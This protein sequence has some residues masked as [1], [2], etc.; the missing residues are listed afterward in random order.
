MVEDGFRIIYS[1]MDKELIKALAKARY[2]SKRNAGISNNRYDGSKCSIDNDIDATGAEYF[3]V[4]QY[5][6]PFNS[7]IGSKGDGGSD[8]SLPL[9]IEVVWLGRG[10][11]GTPRTDGNLIINPDEP[12]RWADIYI[13][14]RGSLED[15]FE[16][17]GWLPHSH[18]I[19]MPKKD[20]GFGRKFACHTTKL[21]DPVLLKALR[22]A[23]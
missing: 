23:K 3:A 15:G 21:K 2:L 13:V 19:K 17:I 6:Q 12:Q 14:I 20:F 9:S 16:E 1:V 22:R 4:Q 7:T 8:F 10:K 11:D 18:L 5:G